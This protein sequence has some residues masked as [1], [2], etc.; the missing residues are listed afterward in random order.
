M[1]AIDLRYNKAVIGDKEGLRTMSRRDMEYYLAN[2]GCPKKMFP[3]VCSP[4]C[5]DRQDNGANNSCE[6]CWRQE[7]KSN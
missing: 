6:N 1:R 2:H 4:K 7:I 5:E 3:K